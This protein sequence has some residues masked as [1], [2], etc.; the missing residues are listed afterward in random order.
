ML[1]AG[2]DVGW[3]IDP[4]RRT[5]GEGVC[6][7]AGRGTRRAN[8]LRRFEKMNTMDRKLVSSVGAAFWVPVVLAMTPAAAEACG[9]LGQICCG[10]PLS[11]TCNAGLTEVAGVCVNLNPC[12]T[13]PCGSSCSPECNPVCSAYDI[14]SCVGE[15]NVLCDP[16]FLICNP[17]CGASKPECNPLCGGDICG[18]GCDDECSP[19]LCSQNDCAQTACGGEG[20]RGCCLLEQVPSCDSGLVEDAPCTNANC[21]FLGCSRA[22]NTQV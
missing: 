5:L 16:L 20:E 2:R 3:V 4:P 21:G 17:D 1:H 12:V 22:R 13:N 14:C 18:S 8:T 9:G 11:C 15:C 19:T 10:L 6:A 7:E